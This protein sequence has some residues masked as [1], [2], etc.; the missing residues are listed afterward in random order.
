MTDVAALAPDP[1]LRAGRLGWVPV[2]LAVLA[3]AAWI[4][5][6]A[7]LIQE[8][9]L[10][11]PVL[12]IGW[13]A[14]FVGLGV[15][16]AR[17]LAVRSG[18][19]WPV[20]ALGLVVASSLAG[21][22][23]APEARDALAGGRV[24]TAIGAN[25]G[26][27]LAGL[28][29][30]RGFPHGSH[31]LALGTVSRMVFVAVPVLG[32]LAAA[33]G[34]VAEPWRSQFLA[35]AALA[36]V[37]FTA[38]GLLSLAFAGFAEIERSNLPTW[39]G[40]PA[41]VGL[42]L[43]AVALLVAGAMPISSLAGPVI[44]TS[45]QVVIGVLFIPLALASLFAGAGAGFRKTLVFMGVAIAIIWLVSFTRPTIPTPPAGSPPPPAAPIEPSV[46]DRVGLL[47]TG[48]V[49]MTLIA[50]GVILLVRAWMRRPRDFTG[51][52]GDE[53]SFDLPEANDEP[54]AP[55]RRRR[56]RGAVPLTAADAYLQLVADLEDRPT[57]RRAPSETPAEHAA[58]LRQTGETGRGEGAA[59]GSAS[60]GSA[61]GLS[62]LAAD[63]G[64]ATFGRAT[65]SPAE[66]R[67]AIGR[68]KALRGALGRVERPVP[69]DGAVED[70]TRP[71]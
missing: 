61:L 47:G 60:G 28:A 29:I 7:G 48:A 30:L 45:V 12:G 49:L 25:P 24:L 67:R 35:D 66:T 36:V 46:V 10:R 50:I 3:E 68:W 19:R 64:L 38:C 37:V 59:D 4:S 43:V 71:Q 9:A 23:A 16:T 14:G 2:V 31:Q 52:A 20:L 13:L 42:L 34:M 53:R 1:G 32:V 17:L 27:F 58:R 70:A 44:A 69:S 26:G 21:W 18:D 63:Y 41:W 8:F 62:L 15:V 57:V 22:L 54:A 55:R 40:N 5:V 6:V 56:G 39:R 51:D 11:M 33:G 65:I